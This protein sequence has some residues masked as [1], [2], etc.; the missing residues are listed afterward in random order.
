MTA[1]RKNFSHTY[2]E[3]PA[4]AAKGLLLVLLALRR[5]YLNN[6]LAAQTFVAQNQP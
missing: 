2:G 4:K 3:Q 6:F 1:V 5:R